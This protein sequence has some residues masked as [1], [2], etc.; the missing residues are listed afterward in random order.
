MNNEV[1]QQA[2][3]AYNAK[4]YASALQLFSNCMQDPVF[5]LQPGE[6]GLLC[7]Q[8]GNCLM[9]LGNNSEAINAYS[10]ATG[11]TAY[12]ALGAVNCNMGFAYAALRD[13]ENAVT[14]FGNASKDAKYDAHYKAYLGMGNA[15]LKLGKTA[16]AGVAFR[17]AALDEKNPDP[18][19][20]LLN[21]GICFM[22]LN[23]PADAITSYESALQFPMKSATRNKLYANLG[24]AYVACGQ[25]QKA[26]N[27]F[28][29]ALADKT[30]FLSDSASVDYQRAVGNVAQGTME[31]PRQEEP[32]YTD[33]SGF[34]VVSDAYDADMYY[35]DDAYDPG[36]YDDNSASAYLPERTP[37][38]TQD[39]FFNASDEEVDNWSRNIEVQKKRGR[40]CGFKIFITFMILIVLAL[41]AAVFAYTQGYG[42]PTQEA[43]ISQ[44]FADPEGASDSVF[45]SGI[46]DKQKQDMLSSVI[47]DSNAQIE[48]VNRSMSNA[49]AYV[50]AATSAGGTVRYEVSL[51]RDGIGWKISDVELYFTSQN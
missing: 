22:T 15:L 31:I 8:M 36:H 41:G 38:A 23:R 37:D 35:D 27:A 50:T 44:F 17:E 21:L 18:T 42:Y 48:G 40:G 32:D 10:Q 9:K 19:K 28:E 12:D 45:A 43:V 6:T 47:S 20:A 24:Q 33:A 5:A 16:E 49:T 14:R 30:Y 51:A 29:M 26:V 13:Y 1:F 4:D 7:H 11:D 2:Q 39:A 46:T 34:D 25:M 3:T